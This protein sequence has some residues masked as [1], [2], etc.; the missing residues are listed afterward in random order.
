MCVQYFLS[1]LF[2]FYHILYTN[3]LMSAT[4]DSSSDNT[5][6]PAELLRLVHEELNQELQD[7]VVQPDHLAVLH[8]VVQLQALGAPQQVLPLVVCVRLHRERH[9]VELVAEEGEEPT[10]CDHSL[11]HEGPGHVLVVPETCRRGEENTVST[12][13]I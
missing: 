8:A 4:L 11:R 12:R 2:S 10:V 6:E 5:E 13:T 9:R 7:L 1:T 3:V